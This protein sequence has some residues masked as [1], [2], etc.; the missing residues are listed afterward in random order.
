MTIKTLLKQRRVASIE[1]PFI[2]VSSMVI[3]FGL[4]SIYRLMYTQTRVDSTAFILPILL[5]EPL[6]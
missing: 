3:V 2:V 4:V 6:M 5:H 1:F